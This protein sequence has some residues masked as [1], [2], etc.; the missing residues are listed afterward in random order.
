MLVYLDQEKS[1]AGKLNEN[2]AREIMELHT[3][4]VHGGYSQTDV[5][6]LASVLNGWTVMREA[7]APAGG[8]ARC[9]SFTT[10]AT[11]PGMVD[12]FRFAPVLNDGK[13]PARFRHAVPRRRPGRALRPRA[14]RAGDARLASA[15]RRNTSAAS[16]PSITSATRP[17]TRSCAQMAAVYLET[18]GDMR[19]VLR[20]MVAHPAFWSAT[21]KMATP[22]DYGL[23]VARLC[24]AA[25][26][27]G[28][29]GPRPGARSRSRW[30][31]SSRK[32]AWACSTA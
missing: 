21:P 1:Y 19:A 23:R 27:R 29:G 11:T 12:D 13:A 9:T 2:Y 30:K 24:R 31:V 32:A 22:F 20:A 26:R 25:A 18:G 14:A 17:P 8:R 16:S 5:T 15:A 10:A 28:G 7:L 6:A 3:L 4:G